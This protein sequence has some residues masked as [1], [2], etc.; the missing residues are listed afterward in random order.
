MYQNSGIS[1]STFFKYL[2]PLIHLVILKFVKKDKL[3]Y[4]WHLQL[5]PS[6]SLIFLFHLNVSS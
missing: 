6:E 3:S 2:F 5:I 4:P 1:S